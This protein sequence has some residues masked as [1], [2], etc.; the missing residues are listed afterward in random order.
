MKN[1]IKRSWKLSEEQKSKIREMYKLGNNPHKIARYFE[2]SDNSVCNI[3]KMKWFMDTHKKYY[4][5]NRDSLLIKMR[6]YNV[7]YN[8][9]PEIKERTRKYRL[10]PDVIERRKKYEKSPEYK[11]G[12]AVYFKKYYSSNPEFRLYKKEYGKKYR[13]EHREEI[14]KRYREKYLKNK[15]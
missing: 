1:N 4:L 13:N 12:R 6:R 9:R 2:I 10:R 5:K 8:Q 14:N 7:G 11:K 15:K 3:L